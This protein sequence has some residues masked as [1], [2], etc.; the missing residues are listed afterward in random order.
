MA[1]N[2]KLTELLSQLITEEP[3]RRREDCL[4]TRVLY[5]LATKPAS[6]PQ[7]ERQ[8]LVD[9]DYC[10]HAL[11]RLRQDLPQIEDSLDMSPVEVAAAVAEDFSLCFEAGVVEYPMGA[12]HGRIRFPKLPGD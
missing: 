4:S 10:L 3:A 9:C 6:V 11:A 8:H 5:E 2:R 1:E 12:H 7:A